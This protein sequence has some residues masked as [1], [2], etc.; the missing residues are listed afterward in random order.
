MPQSVGRGGSVFP[1]LPL[2]A[3]KLG[4]ETA[5]VLGSCMQSQGGL[6]L[7]ACRGHA[8]IGEC[9][10]YSPLFPHVELSGIWRAA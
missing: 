8:A 6:L 1:A 9:W 2:C 10:V 4:G 5:E 7:E 3:G